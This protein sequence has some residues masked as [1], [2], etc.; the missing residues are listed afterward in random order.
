MVARGGFVGWI[1]VVVVG[2]WSI[3]VVLGCEG[4]F[5]FFKVLPNILKSGGGRVGK[6]C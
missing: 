3:P 5:F 4:F 2:F 1:A 6:E